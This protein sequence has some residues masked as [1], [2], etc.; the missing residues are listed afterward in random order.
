MK[1][2]F[3]QLTPEEQRAQAARCGCLGTDDYCCCQN[4]PDAE[5]R[6]LRAAEEI[7]KV[8]SKVKGA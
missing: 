8:L 7:A 4:V 1:R 6:R 5:T 3:R 2:P